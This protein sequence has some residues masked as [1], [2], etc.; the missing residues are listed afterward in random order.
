MPGGRKPDIA[1]H[2][3]GSAFELLAN[4]EFG[5]GQLLERADISGSLGGQTLQAQ[6][7]RAAAGLDSLR[8]V[9]GEGILGGSRK[10]ATTSVPSAVERQRR[11]RMGQRG[12]GA[13]ESRWSA[14]RSWQP[15]A[16][17]KAT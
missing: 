11:S 2:F 7:Q 15:S 10:L 1:G 3:G 8:T 16:S 5:V 13:L 6:V 12:P 9:V 17:A 14:V 4:F